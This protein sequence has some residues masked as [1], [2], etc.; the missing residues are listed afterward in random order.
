MFY[1]D[2]AIGAHEERCSR[3]LSHLAEFAPSM[4]ILGSYPS[5][6]R[7]PA[8]APATAGAAS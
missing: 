5:A 7:H 2:I 4:K 8:A 6:L 3:A 1:L